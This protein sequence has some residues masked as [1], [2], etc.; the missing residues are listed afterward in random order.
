MAKKNDDERSEYL[1]RS[2][3]E[4]SKPIRTIQVKGRQTL[5]VLNFLYQNRGHWTP[6]QIS[7]I[8]KMPYTTARNALVRL[9]K[10]ALVTNITGKWSIFDERRPVVAN[11]LNNPGKE[12][13]IITGLPVGVTKKVTHSD[14][15]DHDRV[16]WSSES[17]GYVERHEV[18]FYAWKEIVDWQSGW[19]EHKRVTGISLPGFIVQQMRNVIP[20]TPNPVGGWLWYRG[21]EFTMAVAS[22]NAV[23]LYVG[24]HTWRDELKDWLRD[25]PNITD[26]DLDLV[27][28]KVARA[29]EHPRITREF[30]VVDPRLAAVKPQLFRRSGPQRRKTANFDEVLL[31]SQT[32]EPARVGVLRTVAGCRQP[33]PE[34]VSAVCSSST[35]RAQECRTASRRGPLDATRGPAGV[36]EPEDCLRTGDGEAEQEVPEAAG[37]AERGLRAP[38]GRATG[39]LRTATQ[40]VAAA[41]GG[42][43]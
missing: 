30:H 13:S 28:N 41:T 10:G 40:G 22:K 33:L 31:L 14:T 18:Y 27:W 2:V 37:E 32:T 4:D 15:V 42:I 19:P 26:A 7:R 25:V 9:A 39:T 23:Q 35:L 36:R 38:I 8:L 21:R 20:G 24:D 34:P 17:A 6:A 3:G 12:V 29:A 11:V 43:C 5:R 1:S 16:P